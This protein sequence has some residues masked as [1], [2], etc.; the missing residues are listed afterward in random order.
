MAWK[1]SPSCEGLVQTSVTNAP[2][3]RGSERLLL[4]QGH[5]AKS[6]LSQLG[7]GLPTL[8]YSLFKA[9]VRADEQAYNLSFLV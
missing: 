9:P 3:L 6:W 5:R 4:T 2:F 1:Q 7:P 8:S